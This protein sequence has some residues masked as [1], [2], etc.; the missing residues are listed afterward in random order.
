LGT[1]SSEI[2][3]GLKPLPFLELERSPRIRHH[4]TLWHLRLLSSHACQAGRFFHPDDRTSTA[5]LSRLLMMMFGR[6]IKE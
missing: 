6:E 3:H 1:S 2:F 4:L 5:Q